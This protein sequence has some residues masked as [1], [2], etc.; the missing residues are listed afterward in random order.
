MLQKEPTSIWYKTNV[1]VKDSDHMEE[2][3][4]WCLGRFA[5][6]SFTMWP[7]ATLTAKNNCVFGFK[8][9]DDFMIFSLRYA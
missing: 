6:D 8:N 2:I 9:R 7:S 5:V 3:N 1:I 4:R